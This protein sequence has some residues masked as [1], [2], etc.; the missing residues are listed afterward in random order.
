MHLLIAFASVAWKKTFLNIIAAP[1]SLIRHCTEDIFVLRKI[2]VQQNMFL[3]QYFK[4][5]GLS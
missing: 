4:P 1:Y 3:Y 2:R 5:E